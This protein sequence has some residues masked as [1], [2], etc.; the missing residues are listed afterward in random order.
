[1]RRC[2]LCR[3]EGKKARVDKV[4]F[5]AY[6]EREAKNPCSS[7]FRQGEG[8]IGKKRPLITKRRRNT[9]RCRPAAV[10]PPRGSSLFGLS[11]RRDVG[12]LREG[13]PAA[14]IPR[15]SRRTTSC[16]RL[17][18]RA[19]RRLG[20]PETGREGAYEVCLGYSVST[21]FDEFSRACEEWL[22]QNYK[23]SHPWSTS[24]GVP[25]GEQRPSRTG[26]PATHRGRA[27]S[28]DRTE[29]ACACR[30]RGR[31]QRRRD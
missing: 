28:G 6:K 23:S 13:V 7:T 16:V 1:M 9:R 12:H 31:S 20:A 4:D 11:R 30:Q 17:L 22:A 18:R 15:T 26:Q 14:P 5:P 29:A 25:T 27:D 19:R 2:L 24:S 3:A 21:L 10:P 8:R